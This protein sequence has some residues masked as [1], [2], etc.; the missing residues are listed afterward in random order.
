MDA[1]QPRSRW[2]P[3]RVAFAVAFVVRAIFLLF[4]RHSPFFAPVAGGSDRALYDHLAVGV[5]GGQWWPEGVFQYMP[6]YAWVLGLIYKVVGLSNF[7]FVAALG[8]VVDALTCATIVRLARLLGA[9]LWAAGLAAGLYAFY[10]LA[11]IY[12]TLTMPNTL[13]AFL[14]ITFTHLGVRRLQGGWSLGGWAALGLLAG[15]TCLSFAGMLLISVVALVVA[16]V[17]AVRRRQLA[18]LPALLLYVLGVAA[19]IVPITL[20]NRRAEPGFVLITAHGGFNFWMGN[21]ERATGYPVQ[22][23]GFRGDRGSLLLDAMDEAVRLEGR[24]LSSAE[25]S[26]HWSDRARAYWREHPGAALRLQAL[27]FVRFF[28]A[29][30]YDDLR[31]LPMLEVTGT[32]LAW[33]IWPGFG[34]L[35]WLGLFGLIAWRAPVLPRVITAVGILSIISFFITSRYRLTFAPLLAVYAA[36][37]LTTLA[38]AAPARRRW[39]GGGLLA[40][41]LLVWWPMRQTDFRALDHYNAAAHFME[42]ELPAEAL[43]VADRGLALDPNAADLHFVRGNACFGLNRLDEAVVAYE[44]AFTLNPRHAQAHMNLAVVMKMKGDPARARREAEAALALDPAF[45]MARDFLATLP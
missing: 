42:R 15:V 31:M 30:E 5:A 8:A 22:I 26:R 3:E 1:D 18:A 21:H 16:A 6:L 44:R 43:E 12:S 38:A 27:K 29:A 11:V 4:F 25:F 24:K 9:R 33:P 36:G 41:A 13:N 40:I 23:P 37:G 2:T 45:Q 10:P 39:M 34:L 17:A 19:P 35:A 14:L 32:A 20:H 28:Q 7:G